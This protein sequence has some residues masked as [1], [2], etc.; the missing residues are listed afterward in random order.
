MCMAVYIPLIWR[1]WIT[2]TSCIALWDEWRGLPMTRSSCVCATSGNR[3]RL[4]SICVPLRFT[5][6][7]RLRVHV[8]KISFGGGCCGAFAREWMHWRWLTRLGYEAYPIRQYDWQTCKCIRTMSICLDYV[9]G[10]PEK[11]NCTKFVMQLICEPL[12]LGLLFLHQDVQQRLLLK[13]GR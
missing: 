9:Q 11:N 8:K 5:I 2:A 10:V 1:W 12:V 7:Y 13:T 3:W 4:L 6:R